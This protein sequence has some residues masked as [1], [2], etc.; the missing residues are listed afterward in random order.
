MHNLAQ[1]LRD[2]DNSILETTL[3]SLAPNLENVNTDEAHRRNINSYYDS[4]AVQFFEELTG[5]QIHLGYW[6]QRYPFIS[7]A[8]AA[9]RLTTV[10]LNQL[11]LNP[12][13]HLLD[14]GCGSGI[15]AIKIMQQKGCRVD[16]ITINHQ[17]Q[18]KAY[19]SA[20][21]AKLCD[22]SHFILGDATHLPYPND[23]FD[24]TLLLE[25][26]HHIGH[27]QAIREASRVLKPGGA[28][29]IADAVVTKESAKEHNKQWLAETFIAKSQLTRQS[30]ME[31]LILS[32]FCKLEAIDISQSIQPTWTKLTVATRENK[33]MICQNHGSEMYQQMLE[34]WDKIDAIW[35]S[36]AEYV[37]FKAY[38]L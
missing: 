35:S 34:F 33:A 25:S 22:K 31:T 32:G 36:T 11:D 18:Q 17:Q 23:Y 15:P 3:D 37:I 5:Q 19:M 6:D 10:I 26:I 29:L 24:C 4:P 12:M 7:L 13:S 28:I 38:K 21:Q 20:R 30:I 1:I 8:Q 27:E 2:E 16:G 9:D 14:I